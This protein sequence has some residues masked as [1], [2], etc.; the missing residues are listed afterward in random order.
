MQLFAVGLIPFKK[1]DLTHSVDP[2]KYYEYRAFGLPVIATA[3]GEMALRDGATGVFLSE[4]VEDIARLVDAA[5][6]HKTSVEV[7]QQFRTANT[8]TSRFSVLNP[9]QWKLGLASS[10]GDTQERLQQVR[11]TQTSQ[12]AQLSQ[13]PHSLQLRQ[14]DDGGVGM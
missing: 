6:E 5:L 8:W 1:N 7:V 9:A 2:I 12:P 3:F 10:H 14:D 4:G 13:P 11:S